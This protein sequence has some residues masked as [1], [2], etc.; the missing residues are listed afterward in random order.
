MKK[1][2]LAIALIAIAVVSR[3]V[4]PAPNFTAVLAVALFAGAYLG[5]VRGTLVAFGSMAFSDTLWMYYHPGQYHFGI[6]AGIDYLAVILVMTIGMALTLHG[7]EIGGKKVIP[8]SFAGSFAGSIVF[9]LIS[10]FGVWAASGMYPITWNGLA[11][12]YV[13]AI[14]FFGNTFLSAFAYSFVLFAAYEVALKAV[15]GSWF[16]RGVMYN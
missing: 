3:F 8:A 5:G 12:C 2:L 13:A 6:V 4:E 16:T 14:P 7:R 9:F 11:A 10:N 1:T 15:R